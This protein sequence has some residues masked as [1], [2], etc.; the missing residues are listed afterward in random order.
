MEKKYNSNSIDENAIYLRYESKI[1]RI[2]LTELLFIEAQKDYV[3]LHTHENEFKIISSMKQ[4]ADQLGN[5]EFHR[6][7]RSYIVRLDKIDFLDGDE[8]YLKGSPKRI[9]V[10]PSFRSPFLKSVR[11]I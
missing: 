5:K 11:M 6:I 10:G 3:V 8:V 2:G 9:Q 7:H 4:L 1:H